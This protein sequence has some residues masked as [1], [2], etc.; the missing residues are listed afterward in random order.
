MNS[1]PVITTSLPFLTPPLPIITPP[2]PLISP[3]LPPIFPPWPHLISPLSHVGPPF[4]RN[5]H[6]SSSETIIKLIM[7]ILCYPGYWEDLNQPPKKR[8]LEKDIVDSPHYCEL[9]CPSDA[10][11]S[12][13]RK[14]SLAKYIM[15]LPIG[16]HTNSTTKEELI[17]EY[18]TEEKVAQTNFKISSF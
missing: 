10:I 1:L 15:Q 12:H 16:H 17:V 5:L 2:L 6:I 13:I 9:Q 18:T 4:T 7:D 14:A 11:S 8:C 3:P